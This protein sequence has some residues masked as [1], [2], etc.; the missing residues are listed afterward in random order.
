MVVSSPQELFDMA[1][2]QPDS[3]R[4]DLAALLLESLGPPFKEVDEQT[5][6]GEIAQRL[7]ELDSGAVQAVPWPDVRARILTG[8]TGP[9]RD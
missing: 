4:A 7:A 2:S 3:V 9:S 6:S 1:L 5:W 8:N